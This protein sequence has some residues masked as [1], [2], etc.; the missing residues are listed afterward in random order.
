MPTIGSI[1]RR[2]KRVEG[3]KVRILYP[4]GRNIRSDQESFRRNYNYERAA[5]DEITVSQ[6]REGRFEN[7]YPGYG[8]EVLYGNGQVVNGNTKLG[9]VRATY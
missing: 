7:I 8:V 1:E 9:S 4:S 3:F 2:I 5:S 6:W